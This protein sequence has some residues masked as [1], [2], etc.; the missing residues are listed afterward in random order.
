VIRQLFLIHRYLGIALSLVIF[1]WCVSGIVMM[2]FQFPEVTEEERVTG[3]APLD[4]EQ[5]CVWPEDFSNIDI[6]R[7]S[8]E[9]LAGAPVIRLIDGFGEYVLELRDGRYLYEF[10]F[11]A[12]NR[13]AADAAP[14]FGLDEDVRLLG[15][16][17]R[18]QWT[19]AGY[20]RHRPLYHFAADDGRGTEFYISSTTGAVV[21]MTTTIE[22][23]GN[24][25]GSVVHWFYPTVLRQHTY[26]WSQTIIWMTILSLFLT[27]VG[28]YIGFK[29]FKR[30]RN[31]RWSPYRGFA[32]WHHYAG[33]F[34]GVLMLTWLVSG[35]LSLNPWGLLE[36]RGFREEATAVGAGNMQLAHAQR[37][38]AGVG[39]AAL[40]PDT[41]RLVGEL[42]DGRLFV[43]AW[44]TA[45]ERMRFDG[46]TWA[47]APLDD[48]E[49]A[50][51]AQRLRPKA[52]IIEHAWI[53]DPDAY[54]FSHHDV[55]RFPVYRVWFSDGERYYLDGTNGQLSY[56]VDASRRGSRWLF[57]ALHR[58]DFSALI[59]ARPIWD[60]M[61]W[62]LMGGVTIGAATGAWLGVERI[63]RALRRVSHR[64]AVRARATT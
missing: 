4:L 7:F 14:R 59:R 21:Q 64:R 60:I 10:D 47:R 42:F 36:G 12:A 5:C 32:L 57:H 38:L 30:R 20:D 24:W 35:L 51:A 45:G 2:Y 16:I 43:T 3:L 54:Y 13:I 62:L 46:T 17:E 50:A 18:D 61:M 53:D 27:I 31:G 39:R 37:S 63:A 44:T 9:M 41:A 23:I 8:V 55:R 22:R 56:A 26:T 33:F 52:T 28:L 34:F 25:L 49:L 29:Q 48:A 6:Q 19:V 11:A 1:A 40:P 15:L 58:G